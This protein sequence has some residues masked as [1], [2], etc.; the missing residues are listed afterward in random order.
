MAE[1]NGRRVR[2]VGLI[3]VMAAGLTWAVSNGNSQPEAVRSGSV[4][5]VRG[6]SVLGQQGPGEPPEVAPLRE[7]ELGQVGPG[8]N[9]A[10]A[11]VGLRSDVRHNGAGRAVT[12]DETA[13][14]ACA[15][16][17]VALAFAE[18][19]PERSAESLAS[20]IDRARASETPGFGRIAGL[21]RALQAGGQAPQALQ[22]NVVEAF[23]IC[24]AGGHEL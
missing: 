8:D 9:P 3:L 5:E 7:L 24:V 6:V 2:V 18:E 22:D 13:S 11:A 16:L 17:E 12:L 4:E 1:S 23:E 21:L 14:L 20:A 10:P 15:D 19:D